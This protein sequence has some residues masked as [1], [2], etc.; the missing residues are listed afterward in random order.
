MKVKEAIS[1]QLQYSQHLSLR[2]IFWLLAAQHAK[3]IK[4]GSDFTTQTQSSFWKEF[5]GLML[6]SMSATTSSLFPMLMIQS[7]YG[8]LRVMAQQCISILLSFI[9]TCSQINGNSMIRK[10][11]WVSK[12]PQVTRT[13]LDLAATRK[14]AFTRPMICLEC[15]L[16]DRATITRCWSLIRPWKEGSAWAVTHLPHFHTAL[17]RPPA[18][19]APRIWMI[20]SYLIHREWTSTCMILPV[21]RKFRSLISMMKMKKS[22]TLKTVTTLKTLTMKNKRRM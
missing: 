21:D 6:I 18:L 5:Q 14:T 16:T 3:V 17:R 12:A 9:E 22:T 20:S 1:S 15:L 2:E 4:D 19:D 13:T 7:N 8:T 10:N 11:L